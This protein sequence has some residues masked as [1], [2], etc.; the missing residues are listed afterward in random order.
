MLKKNPDLKVSY[1][2]SRRF[3]TLLNG[4]VQN[5]D[6]MATLAKNN[7]IDASKIDSYKSTPAELMGERAFASFISH[8]L[9]TGTIDRSK[10]T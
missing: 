6:I 9:E 3:T 10:K 8:A 2:S 1:G 4:I 7:I 5:P